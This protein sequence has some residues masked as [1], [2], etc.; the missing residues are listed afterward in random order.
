MLVV[1]E[2]GPKAKEGTV[3]ANAKLRQSLNPLSDA[4]GCGRGDCCHA[5]GLEE[6]HDGGAYL[7]SSMSFSV[8]DVRLSEK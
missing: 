7:L 5:S 4:D 8:L 2:R 3:F 1:L 6:W